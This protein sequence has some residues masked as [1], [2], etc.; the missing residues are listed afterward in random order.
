MAY[1]EVRRQG[2]GLRDVRLRPPS[3]LPGASGISASLPPSLPPSLSR[4]L[5]RSRHSLK[6][7]D[8]HSVE[9]LASR[10]IGYLQSSR[11]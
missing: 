5:A 6:T 9:R 4:S 3:K 10:R 11:P 2:R 1:A 8:L 7:Q